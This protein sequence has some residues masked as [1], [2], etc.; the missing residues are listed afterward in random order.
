MK[1][2]ISLIVVA[3]ALIGCHQSTLDEYYVD[4]NPVPSQTIIEYLSSDS[5]YSL[6]IELLN[7]SSVIDTI[8]SDYL[9]TVFAPTNEKLV[10]AGVAEMSEDSIALFMK[11]HICANPKNTTTFEVTRRLLMFSDKY[12]DIQVDEETNVYTA[13]GLTITETDITCLDGIIHKVDGVLTPRLTIYDWLLELGDEY[14]IFVEA[15]MN[16]TTLEFDRENSTIIGE[17]SMGRPIYDSVFTMVNDILDAAD[18][19]DEAALYRFVIPTNDVINTTFIEMSDVYLKYNMTVTEAD[20][21]EWM[22]WYLQASAF[23]Y[24]ES[25]IALFENLD[26]IADYSVFDLEFQPSSVTMNDPIQLSNGYAYQIT[27]GHLPLYIPMSSV[28]MNAS[29]ARLIASDNNVSITTIY[30]SGC[31]SWNSPLSSNSTFS[32]SSNGQI[33]DDGSVTFN[34][35]SNSYFYMQFAYNGTPIF[36]D[37]RLS[38]RF[39]TY[40]RTGTYDFD[41][42]SISYS[43]SPVNVV[44]GNYTLAVDMPQRSTTDLLDQVEI[45]VN[46]YLVETITGI[47]EDNYPLGGSTIV[48]DTSGFYVGDSLDVVEFRVEIVD[49]RISTLFSGD[50]LDYASITIGNFT[51]TPINNY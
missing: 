44:P 27:K 7:S 41:D 40:E 1:K 12:L 36:I 38:Y 18:I 21:T 2:Y 23:D 32:N 33:N 47:T 35:S 30:T 8:A 46:D 10:E 50:I 25:G 37:N 28:T 43:F 48:G 51:L 29:T 49:P 19:Q 17:S 4:R 20:S 26:T 15:L 34:T 5:N 9:Y 45:Y 13:D 24:L 11:M 31:D 42:E 6:F 16:R 3:L 14:S 39:Q 22:D